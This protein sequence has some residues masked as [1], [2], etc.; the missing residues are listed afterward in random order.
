[1]ESK[2]KHQEPNLNEIDAARIDKLMEQVRKIKDEERRYSIVQ[3]ALMKSRIEK[4][5]E[6]GNVKLEA[7]R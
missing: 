2:Q 1:M 6:I 4:E 5:V 3:K 7:R